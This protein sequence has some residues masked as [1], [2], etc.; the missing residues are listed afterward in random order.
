MQRQLRHIA[1]KWS[2]GGSSRL[3]VAFI[4]F[5]Q[6]YVMVPKPYLWENLKWNSMPA[7]LLHVIREMF[8]K[9]EY[10]LNDGDV[11]AQVHPINGVQQ[12]FPLS[13]LLFSM[14]INDVY[15]HRK[16]WK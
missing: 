8:E 16:V 6:L 14:Y 2:P 4:D 1:K 9:D 12:G 3:H 7:P 13:P 15:I 10:V 11:R 5:P